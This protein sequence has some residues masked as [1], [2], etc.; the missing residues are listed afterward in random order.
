M[1]KVSLNPK[2]G[3]KFGGAGTCFRWSKWEK[4]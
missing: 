3:R 1:S 4:M 2:T